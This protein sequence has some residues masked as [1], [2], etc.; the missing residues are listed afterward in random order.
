VE[1]GRG[2]TKMLIEA[3]CDSPYIYQDNYE[4][5]ILELLESFYYFKN[6]RKTASPTM[7]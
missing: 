7:S 4:M 5:T 1:F 6:S 3:F 2:I